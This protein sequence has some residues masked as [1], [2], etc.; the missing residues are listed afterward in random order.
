MIMA[1]MIIMNTPVIM[2]IANR[3][4]TVMIVI[5]TFGDGGDNYDK[6]TS[7]IEQKTK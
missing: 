3:L 1:A 5:N 2:M 4:I 7:Y 6:G